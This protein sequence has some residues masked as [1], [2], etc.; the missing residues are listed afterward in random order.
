ML[1]IDSRISRFKW[2]GCYCECAMFQNAKSKIV[3]YIRLESRGESARRRFEYYHGKT[4]RLIDLYSHNLNKG[5]SSIWMCVSLSP[6][7]DHPYPNPRYEIVA[8]QCKDKPSL[9]QIINCVLK[10]YY[11]LSNTFCICIVT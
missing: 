10:Y 5:Q 1:L 3:S 6:C 7:S 9:S 2:L 8:Y 11:K 4:Y